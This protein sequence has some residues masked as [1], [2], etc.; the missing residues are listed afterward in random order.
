[1]RFLLYSLLK[2]N[3]WIYRYPPG[4]F[5]SSLPGKDDIERRYKEITSPSDVSI[6]GVDLNAE[7]QLLLLRELSSVGADLKLNKNQD[8]DARYF[9]DNATFR[10]SDGIIL[11]S[12]LKYFKPRNVIEVGSGFSSALMLDLL[13]TGLQSNLTFIEPYPDTL[14]R[15]MRDSDKNQCRVLVDKVQ[16]IALDEFRIL[17]ANDILFIDTSHVLKIGSDLSRLFYNV[18]PGLNEGV[19]VHIHDIFWPF[20]YPHEML[21]EGRIWNEIYFV[22]SFL[23]FND[24]FEIMYFNSYMENQYSQD[25]LKNLPNYTEFTGASLWLRK[26][27]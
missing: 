5:G 1:L 25:I 11:A 7:N 13:D 3:L 4:H 8:P 26:K 21:K 20:E 2:G 10:L 12:F 19:I 16:D 27:S 15:L 6:D 14:N 9:Y 24:S 17:D 18:L 23:Q 22:R